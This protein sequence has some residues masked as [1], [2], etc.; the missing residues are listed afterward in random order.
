MAATGVELKNRSAVIGVCSRLHTFCVDARICLET[1][2]LKGNEIVEAVS[3]QFLPAPIVDRDGC[4]VEHLRRECRYP[5][6]F[7][8]TRAMSRTD[9]TSRFQLEAV[10]KNSG[11]K[12][13]YRRA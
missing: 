4:P 6:C 12:R 13:P 8:S 3:G 2:L 5:S 1:E 7:S 11:L 9:A 10:I